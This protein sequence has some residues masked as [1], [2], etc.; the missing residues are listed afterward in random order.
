MRPQLTT[1]E[2]LERL[3]T[4]RKLLTAVL[5]LARQRGH[6]WPGC[7]ETLD[8]LRMLERRARRLQRPEIAAYAADV[9]AFARHVLGE[10]LADA[11]VETRS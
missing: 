10:L 2:V 8:A 11:P 9:E 1:H 5:T 3:H 7:F 4:V 6:A